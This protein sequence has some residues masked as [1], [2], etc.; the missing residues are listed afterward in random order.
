VAPLLPHLIRRRGKARA[1]FAAVLA[2]SLLL[3]VAAR[4]HPLGNFTVNRYSGI[5]I[6]PDRLDV[7][8]VLDIAEVPAFQEK[9]RIDTDRDGIL[10]E[11]EKSAYVSRRGGELSA[12]L[13]AEV[14]GSSL[15][16]SLSSAEMTFSAGEGGLD[17]IRAEFRFRSSP[18]PSSTGLWDLSYRDANDPERIGWKEIVV[19]AGEGISLRGSDAPDADISDALRTYPRSNDGVPARL[20]ARATFTRGAAAA[21]VIGP[22]PLTTAASDDPTGFLSRF[23]IVKVS[24]PIVVLASVLAALVLGAAHAASPGHGKTIMAAYLIGGRGS[25][26][27]ALLLGVTVAVSHTVG[28]IA[29]GLVTLH[30]TQI[31]TPERLYPWLSLLS[32]V[33]V[34]VLGLGFLTRSPRGALW[35][36]HTHGYDNAHYHSHHQDHHHSFEVAA[37]TAQKPLRLT[38]RSL[39][40]L[41]VAGGLVPSA[42]ALILLL[43][44]ISFQQVL[45]GV[46]MLLAFSAGM[47]GTLTGVAL[48]FVRASRVVERLPI[49][50]GLSRAMPLL[51][52]ALVVSAGLFMTA[53]ALLTL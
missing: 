28:V 29:L 33:I 19:R 18:L 37:L 14:N 24:S 16:L 46:V 31:I 51:S 26:S 22:A 1:A 21:P 7:L 49:L 52:A 41:G 8:Y 25:V 48:L 40:V 23:L 2:V 27:Q 4:A 50:S 5:N 36:T 34:T 38:W 53:R 10:S 30:A 39:M 20:N 15:A 47:A 13:H 11:E 45:L 42:S 32:G 9:L 35:P 12:G 17:T 6:F 43:A 3:P 44:A